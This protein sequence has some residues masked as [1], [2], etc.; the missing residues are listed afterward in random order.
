M[1]RRRFARA[2][3]LN[4]F[5]AFFSSPLMRM[6]R[7]ARA[8]L[9]ALFTVCFS[10]L[11]MRLRR[12][13]RAALFAL[14]L[15]FVL[16]IACREG[17]H[18]GVMAHSGPTERA[19]LLILIR[20][21]CAF[22]RGASAACFGTRETNCFQHLSLLWSA[23]LQSEHGILE[24]VCA[25]NLTDV[26]NQSLS[27]VCVFV[28]ARIVHDSITSRSAPEAIAIHRQTQIRIKQFTTT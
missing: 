16:I 13:P 18:G 12:P 5:M 20:R 11:V 22:L 25:L 24:I 1:R 27:I 15:A 3:L 26:G 6:R 19:P 28:S 2:A 10:L 23:L 8:A 17:S 21:F 4:L 7:S 9:L 14:F